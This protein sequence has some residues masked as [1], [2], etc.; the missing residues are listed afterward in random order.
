MANPDSRTMLTSGCAIRSHALSPTLGSTSRA[1]SRYLRH[2][3]GARLAQSGASTLSRGACSA[4]RTVAFQVGGKSRRRDPLAV[5][6]RSN[7]DES[8]VT[9][10]CGVAGVTTSAYYDWPAKPAGPTVAELEEA[11]M[12]NEIRDIQAAFDGPTKSR[13]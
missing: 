2:E 9:S 1:S 8:T 3:V 7:A 12:L 11:Y 5:C 13:G 4:Q 10:A 6:D